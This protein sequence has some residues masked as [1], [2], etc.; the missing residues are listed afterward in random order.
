MNLARGIVVWVGMTVS[1]AAQASACGVCGCV[2]GVSPYMGIV[3]FDNQSSFGLLYRYR[4]LSGWP[5]RGGD[6]F[7]SP[8]FRFANRLD[9]R[10]AALPVR[11]YETYRTLEFRAKWFVHKRLE[12][13]VSV[14][15]VSGSART[16]GLRLDVSGLGDVAF[17]AA[18]HVVR[19]IGGSYPWRHRLM[20]GA[21]AKIPT[22]DYYRKDDTGFRLPPLMQ[23]G[24]GS[25]DALFNAVY[26]A[27]YRQWGAMFSAAYK[28]NGQ[29][30]YL[31]SMGDVATGVASL[32]YVATLPGRLSLVPSWQTYFEHAGGPRFNGRPIFENR[33]S[34]ALMTGA[35]LDVFWRNVSFN[36]AFTYPVAQARTD[37]PGHSGQLL[38]GMAYNVPQTRYPWDRLAAGRTARRGLPPPAE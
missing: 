34:Q 7:V 32:F 18:Y 13:N 27:G 23:P 38:L 30:Y 17:W 22:G 31:E 16:S 28:H 14:P 10:V 26:V 19:K 37:A 36:L 1:F 25:W 9:R 21:G 6:L 15:V 33:I 3:P 11:E 20:L 29:N 24:S 4:T 2:V 5:G 8:F 35:G 12:L